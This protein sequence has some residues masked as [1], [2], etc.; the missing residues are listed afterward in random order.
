[1]VA[2]IPGLV[3]SDAGGDAVSVLLVRHGETSSN[4]AGLLDTSAPGA[5]LTPLGRDQAGGL[6]A[7]L[8]AEQADTLLV[9][10]LLR[11]RQTAAPFAEARGLAPRLDE[12][13]R[14]ISAGELEMRGDAEA[15]RRYLGTI[16]A[17]VSG[18]LDAR[19]PGGESGHE[20]LDRLDSALADAIASGARDLVLVS[21]GALIRTWCAVRAAVPF[22]VFAAHPVPNAGIVAL[23]GTPGDWT[24]ATWVGRPIAEL[25]ADDAA[26]GV[27]AS[28]ITPDVAVHGLHRAAGD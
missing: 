24:A 27:D 16:L 25:L 3:T 13:L 8:A 20:A 9:S 23:T 5:G 7:R 26:A 28:S 17:W 21:H 4:V 15:M 10:P 14:E 18:D 19:V 1:M 11:A 2:P 22:S 6:V 12:R